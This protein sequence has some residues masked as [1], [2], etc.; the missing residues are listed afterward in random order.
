MPSGGLPIAVGAVVDNVGTAAQIAKSVKTGMPLVERITTVTG[1]GINEPKNLITKVGTVVSEIIDQCGGLKDNTVGKFIMGGPMM[2]IAQYTTEIVTNK[3]SSG[4]LLLNEKE[5]HI[6][7][8]KNC[9]RCGR[10]ADVCP[11]FLQPLYISAYALR[12]E[13]DSAEKFS[14]M[15]CIECGSCSF[16][17]PASRPLLQSIRLAKNEIGAKRRKQSAKK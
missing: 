6:P 13:F 8:V 11:A 2:G 10:C 7:D 14:A 3:G 15:D 1:S 16:I 17:C 12:N 4:I 5:A 9:I